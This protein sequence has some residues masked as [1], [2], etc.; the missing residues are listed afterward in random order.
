MFSVSD[1][2]AA[3]S[4]INKYMNKHISLWSHVLFVNKMY[5]QI[6]VT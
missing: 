4:I 6:N 1:Q 2:N 3:V 5:L